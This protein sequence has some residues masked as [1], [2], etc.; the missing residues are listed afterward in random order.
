MGAGFIITVVGNV[1]QNITKYHN[2]LMGRVTFEA[3]VKLPMQY[4]GL[5]QLM[6]LT[7]NRS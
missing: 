1:M 6:L 3:V 5:I 4:I 7:V 2:N